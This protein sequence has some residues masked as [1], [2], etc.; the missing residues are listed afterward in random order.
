MGE[1][2]D[3]DTQFTAMMKQN[4][5]IILIGA[6]IGILGI[7]ALIYSSFFDY[8][9]GTWRYALCK[10]FMEQYSQYP[11]ELKILTVAEKQNSAQIGYLSTNAFGDQ[12]SELMEC[13]YN[14]NDNRVSL[15]RVTLN[16][17]NLVLRNPVVD[18]EKAKSK[19]IISY[20][21]VNNLWND[22][23]RTIMRLKYPGITLESFNKVIP[24]I[25]SVEDIDLTIP[26]AIPESIE[27]LKF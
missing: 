2:H 20:E 17:K 23:N 10:V 5:E 25:L 16:R 12:S 22:Y 18:E 9:S 11:S 7:C 13:F 24:V 3:K 27:D 8:R 14:T 19:I 26:N 4:Q 15:T 6:A 1:I 21:E